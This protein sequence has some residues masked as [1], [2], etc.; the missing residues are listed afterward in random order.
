MIIGGQW[1]PFGVE[2]GWSI[3]LAIAWPVQV[4]FSDPYLRFVNTFTGV[5]GFRHT[6]PMT[7][8]FAY[9]KGDDNTVNNSVHKQHTGYTFKVSFLNEIS[10]FHVVN[11]QSS[12][13]YL[14]RNTMIFFTCLK[15]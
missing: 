1:R 14:T 3:G 4:M 6:L 15:V 12:L 13:R 7:R 10:N 11:N 5:A 9:C 2:N 8:V